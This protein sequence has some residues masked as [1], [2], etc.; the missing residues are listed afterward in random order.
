MV[1]IDINIDKNVN[2]LNAGKCRIKLL[3]YNKMLANNCINVYYRH[4]KQIQIRYKSADIC[5]LKN[6]QKALIDFP[7]KVD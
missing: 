1:K 6:S 2:V 5:D 3:R 4:I 7:P